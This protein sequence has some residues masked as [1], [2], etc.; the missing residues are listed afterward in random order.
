MII[1][2]YDTRGTI[3][4]TTY[5]GAGRI[6]LMYDPDTRI[7][8]GEPERDDYYTTENAGNRYS[9]TEVLVRKFRDDIKNQR[10]KLAFDTRTQWFETPDGKIVDLNTEREDWTR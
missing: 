9:M 1:N 6:K 7:T 8:T 2:V 3:V 5:L 4:S 10:V